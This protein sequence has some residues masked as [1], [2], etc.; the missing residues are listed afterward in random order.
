MGRHECKGNKLRKS[1]DLKSIQFQ[2]PNQYKLITFKLL[3]CDMEP[4][5]MIANAFLLFVLMPQKM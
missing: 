2:V 1:I 4:I 5:R 3:S